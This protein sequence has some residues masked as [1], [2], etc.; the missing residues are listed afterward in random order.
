MNMNILSK[1]IAPVAVITLLLLGFTK[2]EAQKMEFG[3]RFMPTFSSFEVFTPGNG[4]QIGDYTNGYGFGATLGYNFTDHIGIQVE[5]IYSAIGQKYTEVDVE[6]KINLKYVNIPLLLSINTGKSKVV[7]FN[8][9]GG[10]Q[11]GISV[12]SN[13]FTSK[14]G[15]NNSDAVL[16]VKNGDLG[17]AYGAGLDFG[18][19][20]A[21]TIRVGLGFR[22][23]QGL[24]DISD[25]NATLSTDGY[26]LLDRSKVKTYA[27]YAGLSILF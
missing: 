26:Y 15:T 10:P 22:G 19:N 23:V 18:V 11:I 9:V 13:I 21:R 25:N 2:L 8:L 12:G 4:R 1:Q 7:N 17:V 16:S 14:D 27:A 20:S 5:A 6:R 3:L 24:F